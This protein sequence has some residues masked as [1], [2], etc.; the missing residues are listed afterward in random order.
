MTPAAGPAAEAIPSPPVL[1]TPTAPYVAA[2]VSVLASLVLVRLPIQ[3]T[4]YLTSHEPDFTVVAPAYRIATLMCR[5][6]SVQQMY[7]I[8]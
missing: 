8:F 5:L 6:K 1:P 3:Y 7:A 2:L 4:L